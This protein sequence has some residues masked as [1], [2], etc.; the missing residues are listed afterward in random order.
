MGFE[1]PIFACLEVQMSLTVASLS[2][3]DTLV[4]GYRPLQVDYE[5][6][7]DEEEAGDDR[8]DVPLPPKMLTFYEL[9]LG[10]NHV[11]RKWSDTV[12]D[13]ANLLI[14]VPG[15]SDGPGGVLVCSENFI[16]YK[17]P[18]RLCFEPCNHYLAVC[19]FLF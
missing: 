1:N 15:G 7:V 11:T 10:L 14:P 19:C 8:K 18:V 2:L 5:A 13:T 9:D 6:D 16:V 3:V 17:N 12:D 4:P